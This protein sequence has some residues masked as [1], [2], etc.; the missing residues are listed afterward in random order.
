MNLTADA[1][2]SALVHSL[3]QNA[4]VGLL[5]C[6]LLAA[7][8]H[9]TPNARYLAG[10][11]ALALMVMLPVVTALVLSQ[12]RVPVESFAPTVAA[13][14][15]SASDVM[16]P[17]QP[18]R[19]DTKADGW[20]WK[21][22]AALKPWMLPLWLAGVLVCSLR[23][24]LASMHLVTLRRQCAPEQGP[25]SAVVARLA[26]RI[27]VHR[28][29]SVRIAPTAMAPA[30][31]GL[32]RP[33]ILV[34]SATVLGLAPQQLEA[35]LA[36]EL[37]HIRRHDYLV[38]VLQMIAETLFFYHPAI[39]WAS[40]RIRV[41]RELCCDDV[42]VQACGDVVCYAHALT[43]VAKLQLAGSGIALG[44]AGGPL[45]MRI[46]RLFGVA[47]VGRSVPPLW[48]AFTSLAL[49]VALFTGTYAQSQ[50]PGTLSQDSADGAN[51]RG[52]V[53]DA[54][55]GK[56][57]AGA[58]V[59]AQYI[60][61]IENPPRCPIGDCEVL[62]DPRAGR[63]PVYRVT[64]A[65]DGSFDIRGIKPGDYDVA[66]VAPGYSQRYFGQTSDVMPEV[67]VRVAAGQSATSIEIRLTG[68]GS[69]SGRIFSDAGDGLA[70]VEVELLRRGQRPFGARPAAFAFAQTED[71]GTFRF[72]NVPA[73]EY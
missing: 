13:A 36:H 68:A 40:R 17:L 70:G 19:V 50:L 52:R 41:E 46:Q 5:L 22:L 47:S 66:A 62:V 16:V 65:A 60:T 56:P 72:V 42:A 43:S 54:I 69:L 32:F 3:W 26:A 29:I 33:V 63:I 61:G 35:V 57:V 38:N 30:T 11:G 12:P 23:L 39:W 18:L 8:R 15:P 71:M 1:I 59:R 58:S 20:R 64:T 2:S 45:L 24:V 14:I 73:G 9:R 37:A 34:S 49:I 21:W 28:S 4:I 10:C 27:G 31:F 44:A 25:L 48:V 7:L 53:I 67:P 51:L 6:V 55:S